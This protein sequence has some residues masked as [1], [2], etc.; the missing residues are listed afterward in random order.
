MTVLYA[1][2]EQVTGKSIS[3][4]TDIYSLGVL[5]HELLAGVRPYPN[6]T[7]VASVMRAVTTGAVIRLSRASSDR[8]TAEI[9]SLPTLRRLQAALRGDLEAIVRRAMQL[10]PSRRYVSVERLADDLQRF[11]TGRPVSARPAA[12][13]HWLRLLVSRQFAE[14]WQ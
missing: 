3:V 6:I 1:A 8:G 4:A 14:L 13:L 12:P 9:R 11:L 5:L 2:P 7:S 10:E